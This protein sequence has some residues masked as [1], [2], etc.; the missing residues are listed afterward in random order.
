LAKALVGLWVYLIKVI[1]E[2][3]LIST[4][5]GDILIFFFI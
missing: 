3:N 5:F 1:P 2:L 4:F